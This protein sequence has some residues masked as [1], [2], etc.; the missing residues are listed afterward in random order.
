MQPSWTPAS[1]RPFRL[2]HLVGIRHI[3]TSRHAGDAQVDEA[4]HARQLGCLHGTSTVPKRH[5]D[6]ASTPARAIDQLETKR[7]RVKLQDRLARK[8]KIRTPTSRCDARR[9]T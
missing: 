9:N 6:R 5:H 7:F 2:P 8:S 4:N 1:K 3:N